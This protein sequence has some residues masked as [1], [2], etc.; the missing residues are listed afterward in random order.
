MPQP[1]TTPPESPTI[2]VNGAPLAQRWLDLLTAARVDRSVCLVGRATLR[3]LDTGFELSASDVFALGSEVVIGAG[4]DSPPLFRGTVTAV[5]LEQEHYAS[6][7]VVSVDDAA[8]KLV[9]HYATTAHKN[10]TYSDVI[11]KLA[12]EAGL[13]VQGTDELGGP[14]HDYLLQTG[15]GLDYLNS[16]TQRCGVVWWVDDR[17]WLMLEKGSRRPAPVVKLDLGTTL[18]SFAVRATSSGPGK[19]EVSGWDGLEQERL[20]HSGVVPKGRDESEFVHQANGRSKSLGTGTALVAAPTPLD[21][22][23][24][25]TLAE[26]LRG[27]VSKAAVTARG[28]CQGTGL[29]TPMSVVEVAEV[30]PASGKYLVTRVEHVYTPNGFRT[31]FT[32]GPLRPA[33]MVDL[34]GGSAAPDALQGVYP[35]VVTDV[36]DPE[37]LGRLKVQ[38]T[39]LAGEVESG[40]AR[41]VTLGAGKERGVVFQPEVEDEVLVAFEQGDSRRPLVLGGLFSKANALPAGKFAEEGKRQIASRRIASR[42][43]Y[44]LEFSDGDSPGEQHV[45]LALD[46][47]TRLRIGM[48]RIDLEISNKPILVSNGGAKFELTQSGDVVLEGNNV[49]IKAKQNLTLEGA[50]NAK[51]K[52]GVAADIEGAQVSVKGQATTAVEATGTLT[53]KGG[54]VMIN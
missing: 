35:A 48:D 16:I 39:T 2:K 1:P 14:A 44:F 4:P 27:E 42:N 10:M 53:L 36:S 30:G 22:Q 17:G 34:L 45:Q 33:G 25:K 38:F 24:A 52:A 5:S 19:V 3:F 13:S 46:D 23:E 41:I 20:R 32:S 54:M 15:S 18:L 50:V 12:A 7:L 9:H 8:V 29:I 31:H 49:T 21:V 51:L 47:G 28:T 26:A 40:W 37:N 6:E 43:G 11:S